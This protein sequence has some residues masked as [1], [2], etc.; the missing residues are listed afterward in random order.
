[1]PIWNNCQRARPKRASRRARKFW[2]RLSRR[3][4]LSARRRLR[5]GA[6][7]V[8]GVMSDNRFSAKAVVATTPQP[9][10]RCWGWPRSATQSAPTVC[11][12]RWIMN[13]PSGADPDTG[14]SVRRAINACH[15][16]VRP[17][18]LACAV[19]NA[20]PGLAPV[21]GPN[22]ARCSSPRFPFAPAPPGM[23]SGPAVWTLTGFSL[24]AELQA[25]A[26]RGP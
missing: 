15:A 22:P 6:A 4:P 5:C 1:M 26:A 14:G 21:A 16:S 3:P 7:N 10:A 17:R 19:A 23:A 25:V 12:R 13:S 2:L 20:G 9:H 8:R 11:G 24:R 18:G